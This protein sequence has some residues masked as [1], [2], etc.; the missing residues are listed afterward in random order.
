[1]TKKICF[2][3]TTSI[4]LKTFVLETASY[5][6]ANGDYAI[7]FICDYDAEFAAS[8]PEYIRFIPVSM[9]RGIDFS[10]IQAVA[11]L[12]KIFK[13][14]NFDMVQYSTPNASLYA[15]IAAKKANI[16]VRLYC[17][18]GIRYVGMSGVKRLLFRQ[19]EKI[20]CRKSTDIRAVSFKNLD[21]AVDEKLY[22]KEKAKVLGEGGTI[23]VDIS[24]YEIENKVK[25]G[26]LVREK[27]NI[28]KEFVFGFVGRISRD[29]G[30]N[31]L[32]EAFQRLSTEHAVKL[33]CVGTQEEEGIDRNLF[34]WAENSEQ[35][36]FTG[37]IDNKELF[38][39]YAAMDCY[40][41]P[42]YREG[43]G[44]VIQEAAA[45][46]CA[47]ITTDIPGASEVLENGIS[48]LLAEPR[49]S[50]S[51][52]EKLRRIISDDKLRAELGKNARKR[53]EEHFDRRKMLET[54]RQDY[55]VLLKRGKA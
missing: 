3:T 2:V 27:H 10:A 6:H 31:E 11:R 51:L 55:E 15:A 29:K 13:A 52:E 48:C 47:V 50:T 54:Q 20:V 21:F 4:T 1:M 12:Y 19:F 38:K 8:L 30:S 37:Q 34:T 26:K 28:G 23:G 42:T 49:N 39:Y 43:F 14:E 16:P 25:Y 22:K 24:S 9:V 40:V 5:L 17:Q 18:W 35:V 36:I 44:M 32:L 7:T 41:H 45:M 46:G 33:L 53:I